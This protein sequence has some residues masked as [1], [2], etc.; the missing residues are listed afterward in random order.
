MPSKNNTIQQHIFVQLLGIPFPAIILASL[1][2][3][4]ITRVTAIQS[5]ASPIHHSL[6]AL[7][8]LGVFA[9]AIIIYSADFLRDI[10]KAFQI[11]S[12]WRMVALFWLFLGAT[13]LVFVFFHA[14]NL[15]Y[16]NGIFI[17]VVP[18]KMMV[19]AICVLLGIAMY[20]LLKA[21]KYTKGQVILPF[22]IALVISFSINLFPLMYSTNTLQY[23]ILKMQL[24]IQ[25]LV[26][27]LNL[28]IVAYFEMEKDE[29][30]SINNIW[31]LYPKLMKQQLYFV[32]ITLLVWVV[33]N[34][35]VFPVDI[36]ADVWLNLSV[37]FLLSYL[38]MALKPNIFRWNSAYRFYVDLVLLLFLY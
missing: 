36:G 34:T 17:Q 32:V 12:W 16:L 18:V 27:W 10:P 29:Q 26:F 6:M 38:L 3:K 37:L 31:T 4:N 20:Y 8:V 15:L 1:A 28:L 11:K 30:H 9:G 2:F 21:T 33:W 13:L 35:K 22:V 14:Y 7:S 24:P 5:A 23:D 19:I 25:L